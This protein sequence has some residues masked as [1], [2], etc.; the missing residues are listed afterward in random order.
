M[1]LSGTSGT[2]ALPGWLPAARFAIMP[3]LKAP[4]PK[5][6]FLKAGLSG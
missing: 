5:T 1:S 3:F 6:L 4:F 2:R